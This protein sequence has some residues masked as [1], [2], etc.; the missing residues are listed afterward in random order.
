MSEPNKNLKGAAQ[1]TAR[2]QITLTESIARVNR[3]F[4]KYSTRREHFDLVLSFKH[5]LSMC[6]LNCVRTQHQQPYIV[7]EMTQHTVRV[8]ITLTKSIARV[9]RSF[10]KYSTQREH[11]D[12]VLY[13]KHNISQ[14]KDILCQNPTKLKGCGPTDCA[15]PNNFDQVDCM[16]S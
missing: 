2:A 11:F 16:C 10:V 14:C 12:L 5:N 13:F 4:V 8:Q 6:S 15:R 7:F 1:P 9:N 3:S